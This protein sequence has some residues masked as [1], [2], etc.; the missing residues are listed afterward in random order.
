LI[1]NSFCFFFFRKS[2]DVNRDKEEAA[3]RCPD[4]EVAWEK[5]N[6]IIEGVIDAF[7]GEKGLLLD[8][9][10]QV[11]Y[12]IYLFVKHQKLKDALKL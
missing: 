3:Q 7:E 5:Y 11:K 6:N 8:F 4:A 9:H 2:V 1:V 10:G 12:L